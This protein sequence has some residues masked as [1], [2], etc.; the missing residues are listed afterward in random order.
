[1]RRPTKEKHDRTVVRPIVDCSWRQGRSVVDECVLHHERAA[2][3]VGRRHKDDVEHTMIDTL[4]TREDLPQP[5]RA[6]PE[7]LAAAALEVQS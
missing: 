6:E 2:S 3:V 1:M 5:L 4:V 7:S